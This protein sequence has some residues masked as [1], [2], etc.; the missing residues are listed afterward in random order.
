M[1][2]KYID[3]AT[4]TIKIES[5]PAE[6]L[7]RFLYDN[8]FGKTAALPL[9]KRKFL[10][11][12]YGRKMDSSASIKKIKPFIEKLG[13]N[14]DETQLSVDEFKSFNDFFCRKLKPEVRPIEK[15]LVSPGDGRLLAFKNIEAIN[16]FFIKG[17][18]FTLLDFLQDSKL[19]K[20]YEGGTF[21]ICD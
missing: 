7:L 16:T 21:I 5:P 2:I 10:T 18:K 6:G 1:N 14:M 4:G 13:I 12:Y 8:P 9:I 15:G 19:A 11:E 3:R 20:K 17:R